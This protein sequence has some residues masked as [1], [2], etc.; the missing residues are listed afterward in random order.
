M[1]PNRISLPNAYL[2]SRCHMS[3]KTLQHFFS[4]VL[5]INVST[6]FLVKQISKCSDALDITYNKMLE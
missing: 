1:F 6:G 5:S 4:D 2:K 3:Y